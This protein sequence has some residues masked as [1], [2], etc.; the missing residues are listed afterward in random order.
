M[1]GEISQG[2][3]VFVRGEK[4]GALALVFLKIVLKVEPALA[5]RDPGSVG[6]RPRRPT[7]ALRSPDL[8]RRGALELLV[9]FA[10]VSLRLARLGRLAPV[11]CPRA[12]GEVFGAHP[13][14]VL[15]THVLDFV[16][17]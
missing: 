13:L 17:H 4:S 9:H 16:L 2:V 8:V 10:I 11:L 1:I 6:L 3:A 15:C 12:R 5:S 7:F 14:H